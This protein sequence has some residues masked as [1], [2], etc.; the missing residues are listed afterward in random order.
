MKKRILILLLLPIILLLSS[1]C[2]NNKFLTVSNVYGCDGIHDHHPGYFL[3]YQVNKKVLSKDLSDY[4]ILQTT[5]YHKSNL[6]CIFEEG[7]DLLIYISAL[8]MYAQEKRKVLLEKKYENFIDD[9]Y[10]EKKYDEVKFRYWD[11]VEIS[12][13]MCRGEEKLRLFGGYLW[14]REDKKYYYIEDTI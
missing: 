11:E 2:K 14:F 1:S 9:Y 7:D 3:E 13:Y 10:L 6:D 5:I 8:D 12:F 4:F